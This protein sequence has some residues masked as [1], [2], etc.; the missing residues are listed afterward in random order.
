MIIIIIL[1]IKFIC[2]RDVLLSVFPVGKT[3]F[4]GLADNNAS[5]FLLRSEKSMFR[6]FF[7]AYSA[8]RRRNTIC[9]TPSAE[10]SSICCVY[11]LPRDRPLSTVKGRCGYFPAVV[12]FRK[13]VNKQKIGSAGNGHPVI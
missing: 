10:I 11:P 7:P 8:Q 6:I 12:H 3:G 13:V 4:T 9:A 5:L 2:R 1:I